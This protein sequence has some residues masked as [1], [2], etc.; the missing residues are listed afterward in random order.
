MKRSVDKSN[1]RLL[2]KQ[3]PQIDAGCSG[4]QYV[5]KVDEESCDN[6]VLTQSL[7]GGKSGKNFPPIRDQVGNYTLH[8]GYFLQL[9]PCLL[10]V[11]SL[12]RLNSRY[13]PI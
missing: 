5:Q 1:S 11:N 13:I 2:P 10:E 7:M 4:D 6:E 9:E 12:F 3:L 8:L